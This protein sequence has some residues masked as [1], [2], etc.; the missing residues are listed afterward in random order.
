MYQG[1]KIGLG[2]SSHTVIRP[3]SMAS[4]L[5]AY[6]SQAWSNRSV[7]QKGNWNHNSLCFQFLDIDLQFWYWNEKWIDRT[8]KTP[9]SDKVY[10]IP[11]ILY[12]VYR[13]CT[14]EENTWKL[15][16]FL[17]KPFL[18]WGGCGRV[19]VL[20]RQPK[21]EIDV[22]DNLWL[23]RKKGSVSMLTW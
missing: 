12:K 5:I 11:Y 7:F 4:Q 22:I 2:D 18:H 23:E 14:L 20:Q 3:D 1:V 15:A 21:T 13:A 8:P 19:C 6:S 16:G 9:L 17:W 10:Y